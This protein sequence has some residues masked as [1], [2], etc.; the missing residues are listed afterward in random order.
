MTDVDFLTLA[1]CSC[2]CQGYALWRL[3]ES[4]ASEE[5][6]TAPAREQSISTFCI[7]EMI[8]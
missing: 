6:G 5:L 2:C 3:D 8:L 1:T 7:G 4:R